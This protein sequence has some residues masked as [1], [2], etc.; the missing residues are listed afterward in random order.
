MKE[1]LP[2]FV[3]II[4]YPKTVFCDI[5]E[6]KKSKSEN[7]K[8]AI[9]MEN[10]Y[11]IACISQD[12]GIGKDGDLIWKI[13]EDM[14]FFR[15][16]TLNTTVIMGRRT[17]ASLGRALPK[18]VNI[19]LSHS[20]VQDNNV[21]TF[22]NQDELLRHLNKTND[23]K[24]IIG[25]ASLYQMYLDLADK[26]YLTEVAATKPADTYFPTFDKSKYDRKV[27]QTGTYDDINF[28]IVEYTRK[29]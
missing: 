1:L 17:Y 22:T 8:Q 26:L 16:T 25:G 20:R 7:K 29:K 9:T 24:F 3:Q 6:K 12:N 4:S 5:I 2:F 19:I 27:L 10:L 23:K 18:R 21:E 14:R 28:E 13:P 15:T 11:L